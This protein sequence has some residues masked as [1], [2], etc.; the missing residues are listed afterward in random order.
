MLHGDGAFISSELSSLDVLDGLRKS[1]DSF[2]LPIGGLTLFIAAIFLRA[3]N[4]TTRTSLRRQLIRLDPL[5]TALF[6][7]GVICLLLAL[8]WGGTTYTWNNARIIALFVLAGIL[9]LSFTGVQIWR[10]EDATIPPRI[11]KQRSVAFGAIYTSCLA[12]AM[13]SMLYALPL[14]FQGVKGTSAVQSGIDNIPMVLSLVVSSILSG[15]AISRTGYYVPFMFISSILMAVGSGLITTFK[16]DTSHSAWIGYQVLFGLGLGTGMQQP[17]MAAQTVLDQADVSI[18]VA[19]MFLFQSLG[20]AVWVAVSQNLYTGYLASR[21]PGISGVDAGA[22]LGAGATGLAGIVPA[23]Q[24]HVVLVVYNAALRRAFILPV[25]LSCVMVLP[26]MGMEWR[27]LKRESER[28]ELQG[29][30][31]DVKHQEPKL[32]DERSER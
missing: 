4:I 32:S 28:R 31:R 26:A 17:T 21:V 24:L 22:I 11:I 14:W 3:P 19:L 7:P 5:G 10:K 2:S 16:T 20:G 15:A 1:T 13:I 29:L 25:V 12:G 18:G 9:L 8:Q 23:D 30:G 6:L 27:N